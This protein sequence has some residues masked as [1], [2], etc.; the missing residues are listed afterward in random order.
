MLEAFV[1]APLRHRSLTVFPVIAPH[2][3]VLPYLLSTEIHESGV[4]TVRERGD[5]PDPLLLARN[6]SLHPL[7]ILAGE[8][9]PGESQGRLVERS[10]LLGGKSVTQIPAS[11]VERG[12]WVPANQESQITE[13]LENFPKAEDQ[14]GFLAFQGSRMMGLEALGSPNL[15]SPLHR[16]LLIRFVKR[17]LGSSS[18]EEE[19]PGDLDTQ[20]QQIVGAIADADRTPTKR[21]GVGEYCSLSGPVT[22]GDLIHR[23][24]LVH[25]SVE[26]ASRDP[27]RPIPDA[28]GVQCS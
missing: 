3:P 23:G 22:G 2:G 24:R 8:P 16:R 26:S 20:A 25:L 28:G 4:L 14:V 19:D 5:V 10:I 6:N 21:V 27:A 7:L 9:L 1:D 12:G 11:P 15:Y 18:E 17:V 13:W